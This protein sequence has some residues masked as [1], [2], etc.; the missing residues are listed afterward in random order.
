MRNLKKTLPLQRIATAAQETGVKR[1]T[2]LAAIDRGEI[3]VSMLADG[4]KLVT[5]ADV[6]KWDKKARTMGRPPR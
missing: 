6:L 4:L 5:V 2:I 1:T 3:P